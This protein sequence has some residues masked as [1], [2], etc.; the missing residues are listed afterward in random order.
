MYASYP[1][2]SIAQESVDSADLVF[3]SNVENIAYG[4]LDVRTESGMIF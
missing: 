2:Y 3:S 1:V 4:I